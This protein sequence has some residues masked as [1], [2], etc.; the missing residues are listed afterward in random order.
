MQWGALEHLYQEPELMPLIVIDLTSSLEDVFS[1]HPANPAAAANEWA[2]AIGSYATAV[3][4]AS[5]TV[6]VAQSALELALVGAFQSPS[7]AAP[8]E[9]ALLAF[10]TAV[11][12]GMS[13]GG[14]VGVPPVAPIGFATQFQTHPADPAL[15]AQAIANLIDV[16]L[17]TGTAT[18]IA[19]G[20]V[21]TWL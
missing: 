11:A 5:T 20:P 6:A 4:P 10:A 2:G 9:S 12:G 13:A 17:K 7:A 21:I 15:A 1:D 3:V 18:P 19:G 8:M 14:F 16:W